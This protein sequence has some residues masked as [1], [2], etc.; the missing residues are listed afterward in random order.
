[1]EAKN[2]LTGSTY[3][4]HIVIKHLTNSGFQDNGQEERTH[5]FHS[6]CNFTEPLIIFPSSIF[7]SSA[8]FFIITVTSSLYRDNMDKTGEKQWNR[9]VFNANW[10][11]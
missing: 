11:K 9:K 1:M 4:H 5:E 6:M 3:G 8:T 7:S 2:H 10:S